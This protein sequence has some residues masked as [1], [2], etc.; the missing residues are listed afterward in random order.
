MKK[1]NGVQTW[2]TLVFCFT[3]LLI[4]VAFF[5]PKE[6]RLVPFV[7]GFPTLGLLLILWAGGFYPGI[8]E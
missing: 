7:V 3:L 6:V 1:W 8:I 4:V 5:Y 2:I